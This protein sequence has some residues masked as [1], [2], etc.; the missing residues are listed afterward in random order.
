MVACPD[1]S[2]RRRG[3]DAG[4]AADEYLARSLHYIPDPGL[5]RRWLE[6]ASRRRACRSQ[7][8]LVVRLRLFPR[9]SLLARSRVPGRCQDLWLA[10]PVRRHRAASGNGDLYGAR[11]CAGARHLDAWCDPRTRA[12]GGAHACGV[13]PR[14]SVQR[15]SLEHIRLCVDLAAVARPGRGAHRDLGPHIPRRRDLCIASRAGRCAHRHQ[16]S[17]AGSGFERGGDRGACHL[18]RGTA[19]GNINQLRRRRAPSHHAAQSAAGR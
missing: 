4:T 15:V 2:P 12:R 1:R 5:A 3:V 13:V 19:G 17:L 14:S 9:W 8:G 11:A 18:R 10:A 16:A 6:W 7:R